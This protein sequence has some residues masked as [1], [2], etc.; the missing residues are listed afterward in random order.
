VCY[1]FL[2]FS[3]IS[4]PSSPTPTFHSIPSFSFLLFFFRFIINQSHISSSVKS[5][6]IVQSSQ[7]IVCNSCFSSSSSLP[8]RTGFFFF[9]T[10]HE[11]QVVVG[12]EIYYLFLYIFSCLE[13]FTLY[14]IRP[15]PI[16]S[17]YLFLFFFCF[18]N[19]FI[20]I[21]TLP[22]PDSFVVCNCSSLVHSLSLSLSG[23]WWWW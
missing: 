3:L 6:S 23:T 5:A 2:F 10:L 21:Y 18:C 8:L 13:S 4:I 20:I 9:R 14:T 16:H 12:F 19:F 22:P 17:F 7:S 15:N 11:S 1:A